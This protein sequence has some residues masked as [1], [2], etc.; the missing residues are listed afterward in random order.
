MSDIVDLHRRACDEFDTRV[1]AVGD[2]QWNVG[3]PCTEWDVRALVNHLVN[4][5]K[6]TAPLLGGS[7]IEEVG[8]RF[9][10]DLL[11]DDPKGAWTAAADEAK[12]AV[13]EEGA[14]QRT[15]HVSWG[16]ISGEEYANQLFTDHLIHAWDLARAIGADDKL[17]PELVEACYAIA[18]PQEDMFKASGY[19]GDRIEPPEDADMQ[20]KLLAVF[21]RTP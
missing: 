15:V 4:E 6:W 11:G 16:E 8:D 1:R 10:G 19:F 14:M 20:T 3:T 13:G 21:G 9:D 7:T 12:A 2:D 18:K 5:D 17:D